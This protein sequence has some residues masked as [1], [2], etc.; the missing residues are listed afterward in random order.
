MS[1][2]SADKVVALN[3]WAVYE[4]PTDYPNSYVARLYQDEKP[5]EQV[6]VASTL[7]E[8]RGKLPRGL[9]LMPP[10]IADDPTIIE[11]WF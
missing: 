2:T 6:I 7:E 11:T 4:R 3:I 8:V 5:T 1:E 9:C 10:M